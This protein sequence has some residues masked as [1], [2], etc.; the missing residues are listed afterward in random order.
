MH[1]RK[2][3]AAKMAHLRALLPVF[4]A[5]SI[6]FHF[7]T[8]CFITSPKL[9]RAKLAVKIANSRFSSTAKT[10]TPEGENGKQV[11]SSSITVSNRYQIFYS[12]LFLTGLTSQAEITL[13]D[14]RQIAANTNT[15]EG[16]MI[17]SN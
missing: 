8:F 1:N 15:Q 17:M 9:Q 6:R 3:C 10:P 4:W 2:T 13:A 12:V 14:P 16:K 5:H 11:S 7:N